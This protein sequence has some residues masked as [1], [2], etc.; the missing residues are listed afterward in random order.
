ML[1]TKN[2]QR[3]GDLAANT[4][5][6]FTTRETRSGDFAGFTPRPVN[7]PL[8]PDEQ[9]AIVSYGERAPV[10]NRDRAEELAGIVAPMFNDANTEDL[11]GHAAWLVGRGR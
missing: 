9:N 2:M 3:L 10:L 11:V 7:I 1:L 5:V 6:V 8:S 4:V